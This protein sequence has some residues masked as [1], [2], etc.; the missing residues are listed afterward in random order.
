VLL[1]GGVA[2]LRLPKGALLQA[3]T[4]LTLGVENLLDTRWRDPLWR[5]G[6]VAPQPGR[7]FRL[8]VQVAP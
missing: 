3:P 1:L 2:S 5:A 8:T 4:S 6:L 7:N